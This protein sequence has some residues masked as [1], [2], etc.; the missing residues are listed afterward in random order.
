MIG[1][2]MIGDGMTGDARPL[3]VIMGVSGCGKTTIGIPLAARLGVRFVDGDTL[4]P[5]ANVAKM[6]AGHPLDDA[7][8][9]PWLARVGQALAGA[10]AAGLV[11]ACSAL[12]RSYR[13]AIRDAA[14]TTR[15]LLLDAPRGVLLQRLQA[16][17]GHFMPA[18][19]LDSQLV[20]LE[21]PGADEASVTVDVTPGVDAVVAASLRA[22]IPGHLRQASQ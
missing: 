4:H 11:I 2:G 15:F 14:P 12:K 10:G 5:A 13:D 21:R 6:A 17:R 22:L 7:D 19:L 8:R 20:T 16:R 9:W 3:I 18:S 1:D